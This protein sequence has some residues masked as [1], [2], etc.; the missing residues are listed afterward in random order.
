MFSIPYLNTLRKAEIDDI[1]RHFEP[2]SRVLEIG[3]GTGEQA[4]E[5]NR[6]GFNITAIEIQ[7]SNY[8]AD[9]MFPIMNYDGR[10][11]PLPDASVDIVFS[12]NVLEHI[13]DLAQMHLEI[14]RVLKPGGHCVH[15]LPTHSWR[16]WTII[17]SYPDAF[18]CLLSALPSLLPHALPSHIELRRLTNAWYRCARYIGGRIYQRRHGETGTAISELWRFH[19]NWW[20]HNFQANGFTIVQDEPMGTL[21]H[22]QYPAGRTSRSRTT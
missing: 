6:R 10:H 1:V 8:A 12:S 15:V 17:S 16:F 14:S 13:P 4:A 11:I 21:L 5:L 3:A 9:R 22:R 18:V 2:G 20:R 19:P 7:N